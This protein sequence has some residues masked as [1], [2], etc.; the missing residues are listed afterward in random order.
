M[1][2]PDVLLHVLPVLFV[3]DVIAVVKEL[4]QV[5]VLELVQIVVMELVK[6]RPVLPDAS[7]LTVILVV[8]LN[9]LV[10]EMVVL[11]SVVMA[12]EEVYV[13]RRINKWL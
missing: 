8:L 3:A 10:V 9:V 5:A 6:G 7:G 11:Q 2:V 1:A 4:V 12:V 13:D